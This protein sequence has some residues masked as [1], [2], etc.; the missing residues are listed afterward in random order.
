MQ[1]DDSSN[2][3]EMEDLMPPVRKLLRIALASEP[4]IKNKQRWRDAPD[5]FLLPFVRFA[6]SKREFR[7]SPLAACG[8]GGNAKDGGGALEEPPSDEEVAA[9]TV[10]MLLAFVRYAEAAEA[11]GLLPMAGDVERMRPL[12]MQHFMVMLP[13]TT[14]DADGGR[15]LLVQLRQLAKASEDVLEQIVCWFFIHSC[16]IPELTLPGLCIVYDVSGV[17]LQDAYRLLRMDFPRIAPQ[18]CFPIRIRRVV[19]TNQ[20]WWMSV[21]W[22]AVSKMLDAKLRSRITFLGDDAKVLHQTIGK[23]GLPQTLGGASGGG[24]GWLRECS[25]RGHLLQRLDPPL[26]SQEFQRRSGWRVVSV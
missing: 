13:P 21:V 3:D 14:R 22:G 4:A 16:L 12:Y 15:V 17:T 25:L 9:E 5:A 19:V 18:G 26:A 2:D 11:R 7:A 20:P 6:H 1:A 10:Q 8:G 24:E 23:G